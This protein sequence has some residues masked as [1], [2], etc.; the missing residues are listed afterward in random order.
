M[1]VDELEDFT[2]SLR[3]VFELSSWNERN[4]VEFCFFGH[5]LCK[6]IFRRKYIGEGKQHTS[7]GRGSVLGG[8]FTSKSGEGHRF[9]R[10]KN[11]LDV[12]RLSETIGGIKGKRILDAILT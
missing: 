7:R 11:K 5:S 12:A 4:F 2:L 10:V 8:T 6:R 9:S 1:G 3:K